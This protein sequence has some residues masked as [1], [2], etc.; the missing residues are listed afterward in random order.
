M[1]HVSA[2][3]GKCQNIPYTKKKPPLEA[4]TK[5]YVAQEV[6]L[7]SSQLMPRFLSFNFYAPFSTSVNNSLPFA[8]T[9]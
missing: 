6:E 9:L 4:N 1:H 2:L 8:H 3:S 5:A 7:S